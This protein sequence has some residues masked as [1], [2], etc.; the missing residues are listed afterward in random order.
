[1][2]LIRVAYLAVPPLPLHR[3]R[4]APVF[5]AHRR[6]VRAQAEA[7]TSGADAFYAF[8]LAARMLLAM[9]LAHPQDARD[10][11]TRADPEGFAE[12]GG[13][14]LALDLIGVYSAISALAP[15]ITACC[16]GVLNPPSLSRMASTPRR[17][18]R[19]SSRRARAIWTSSVATGCRSSSA[20]RRSFSSQAAT[21]APAQHWRIMGA[22]EP[23][24]STA[25]SPDRQHRRALRARGCRGF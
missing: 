16:L 4:F 19:A 2:V 20:M 1:M 13:H 24:R 23:G 25:W 8:G 5:L 11:T 21:T 9:K 7:T 12:G 3:A 6:A 17:A 22:P 15:R 10:R 18:S 14:R